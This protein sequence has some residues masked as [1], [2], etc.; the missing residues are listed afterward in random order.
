MNARLLPTIG[1]L[2][3]LSAA[4]AHAG[5]GGGCGCENACPC[6]GC[7]ILHHCQKHHCGCCEQAPRAFTREMPPA[8]PVVETVPMRVMPMMATPMMFAAAVPA[9]RAAYEEAP[10]STCEASSSRLSQLEDRFNLLNERVN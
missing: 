5:G 9:Q 4:T 10:R 1:L 6:A 8:G 3:A 7:K 2:F